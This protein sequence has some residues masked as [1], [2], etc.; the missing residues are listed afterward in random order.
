[1]YYPLAENTVNDQLVLLEQVRKGFTNR[2]GA[3]RKLSL[4]LL[5]V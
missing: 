4:I 5:I 3:S 2:I 1:M